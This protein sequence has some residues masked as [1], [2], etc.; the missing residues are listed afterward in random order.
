MEKVCIYP[1][2]P[3][4]GGET[5]LYDFLLENG[6]KIENREIYCEDVLVGRMTEGTFFS[7]WPNLELHV[8]SNSNLEKMIDELQFS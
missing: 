1:I 8:L 6:F 4:P 5:G 7:E 3:L 2:D